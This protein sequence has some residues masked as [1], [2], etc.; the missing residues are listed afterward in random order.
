MALSDPFHSV[1]AEVTSSVGAAETLVARW[2]ELEGDKR[3]KGERERLLQQLEDL[4]LGV[5]ADL[6]DLNQTISVVE[7]QRSRFRIDDAELQSRRAFVKSMQ[8][9]VDSLCRQ[10]DLNPRALGEAQAGTASA[11]TTGDSPPS[12]KREA[13]REQEGLLAG[14]ASKEAG[15]GKRNKGAAEAHARM[16]GDGMQQQQLQIEQQDEMLDGLGDVVGRLKKQ[17][18]AMNDELKT[19][20]SMLEQVVLP[21][22]LASVRLHVDLKLPPCRSNRTRLCSIWQARFVLLPTTYCSYLSLATKWTRRSSR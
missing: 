13:E 8:G 19:Q 15:V 11:D 1:K 9:L 3:S 16:V 12:S 17:G 10:V 18:E 6:D 5:N 14:S 22:L 21:C 20:G 2:Q 4:L 7:R